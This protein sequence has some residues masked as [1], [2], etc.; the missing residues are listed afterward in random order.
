MYT[1]SIAEEKTHL[2]QIVRQLSAG[3]VHITR[4]GKSV[5]VVM[6]EEEY[7]RLTRIRRQTGFAEV[8]QRLAASDEDEL[9]DDTTIFDQDRKEATERDVK[10]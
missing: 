10:F 5:A 1:Y 7:Q 9:L 6:S 8:L 4:H 2:P 3:E